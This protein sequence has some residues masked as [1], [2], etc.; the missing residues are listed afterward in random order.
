MDLS[1][2]D[3]QSQLQ[4]SVARFVQDQYGFERRQVTANTDLGYDEKNWQQFAD[5]GWLGMCFS[6]EDGGFGGG[7]VELMVVMEEFGKGLVLEPFIPTVVCG[8]GF[9]K[10]AQT[11]VR[12]E[13]IPKVIAGELQ[14]AFAY[15]EASGRYN[16]CDLE[17]TA[18]SQGD[19]FSISGKKSV[20]L[21]APS[22]DYLIVSARTS[23]NVRDRHGV[24]LFLV[25]VDAKGVSRYDYR[26][27]DALRASEVTLENVQVSNA[28]LIGDLDEGADILDE[29]VGSVLLALGAEAVG[30]MEVLYKDT[31]EYSKTR[32]QFGVP[33]GS[34]QVLQ[35]RMVDMFMEHEQSKSLLYMTAV[36]V[37]EGGVAARKAVSALKAQVGRAGR[38]VGQQAVQVHGGM[39]MTEELR[40]GHYF[41]RLTMINA[42]FGDADYHLKHFASL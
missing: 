13:L 10:H 22:A 27:N 37:D 40:V 39:G 24:S 33:I 31:V 8:G 16:L 11:S 1:L 3:L 42:T 18:K 7:S 32:E 2:D 9:L 34:F 30:S 19:G 15:A 36:R 26:T 29:V 41:K 28:A 35:H 20:V 21:N 25:P 23:G 4:S 5:L 6:E 14:L 12:E 38:F 17:T